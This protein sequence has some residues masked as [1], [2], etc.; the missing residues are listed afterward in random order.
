MRVSI[1][2]LEFDGSVLDK[3]EEI[4]EFRQSIENPI[5]HTQ[6]VNKVREVVQKEAVEAI[7]NG[8]TNCI[9]AMATGAGKTKVA[10]DYAKTTFQH[11]QVLLVPTEKLRDQNW[12]EEYKKWDAEDLSN[13][14]EK[15]CYASANKVLHQKFNVAILDEGHNIT[16]NNSKFF[17][18]NLVLKAVL[19]TATVPD[20]NK[21]FE[22]YN[23]LK[24][25]DFKVVYEL[26]LDQAV[27][28]G[29]VAPYEIIVLKVPMNSKD[30]NIKAGTKQKPFMTT[31]VKGYEWKSQN[32][33]SAKYSPK[34]N[35]KFAIINRMRFIYNLPSKFEAAKYLLE[36]K[37]PQNQR[38]LI[39]CSSIKQADTLSEHSFHSKSS[40]ESYQ[41][42][43]EKEINRLSCVKSLNEGHNFDEVDYAL[44]VQL[45]S[46]EKDIIQRLGRI[47]RMR[48]GHRAK[49][50]ILV[51]EGTQDEV[52][53][54]KATENLD[55]SSITYYDFNNIKKMK[56]YEN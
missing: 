6:F 37:I 43:K 16:E 11:N 55:Q 31:E 47:I 52:W 28:L 12:Q 48:A 49:A 54:Q 29:F 40:S 34:I 35:A 32:V 1:E 18:N 53:L 15:Y 20:Y 46:K 33:E 25:L 13:I 38:G 50:F 2:S 9:V 7:K 19:L 30:K 3:V 26:T 41:K 44:I 4:Y 14:T 23:L 27:K 39:F 24:S 17:S 22:K 45:T 5:L 10:I 56:F 8:P 36:N 42:F 51:S 21:D